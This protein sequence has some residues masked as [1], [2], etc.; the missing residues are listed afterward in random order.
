MVLFCETDNRDY[1]GFQ[2]EINYYRKNIF[3]IAK[4][5][6]VKHFIY[7]SVDHSQKLLAKSGGYRCYHYEGKALVAEYI[8][9]HDP[10]QIAWTIVTTSP[11][12]ENLQS[13]YLPKKDPNNRDQLLF[14]ITVG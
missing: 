5:M 4:E 6:D 1:V 11:Y 10:K 12:Y 3:D 13:A 8:E 9:S 2:N 7:S 14:Y